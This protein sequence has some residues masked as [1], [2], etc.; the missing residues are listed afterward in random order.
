MGDGRFCGTQTMLTPRISAD[1]YWK[2][3]K[4]TVQVA[5][6]GVDKIIAR[7]QTIRINNITTLLTIT[8]FTMAVLIESIGIAPDK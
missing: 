7:K 8:M 3:F 6:F 1:S 2:W 4:R 5:H